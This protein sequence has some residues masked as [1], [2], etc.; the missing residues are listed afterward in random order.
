MK[1]VIEFKNCVRVSLTTIGGGGGIAGGA[2]GTSGVLSTLMFSDRTLLGD[3]V[4]NGSTLIEFWR[5]SMQKKT[6]IEILLND[7]TVKTIYAAIES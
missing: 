4:C 7:K 5:L 6:K 1:S 2:W 3:A